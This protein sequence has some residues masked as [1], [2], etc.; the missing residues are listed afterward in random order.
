MSDVTSLD[1][2]LCLATEI[3]CFQTIDEYQN[4]NESFK[5]RISDGS[6]VD[7]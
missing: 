1:P 2:P 4:I 5:F 3:I 7:E 6:V